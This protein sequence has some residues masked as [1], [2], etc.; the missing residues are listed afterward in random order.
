MAFDTRTWMEQRTPKIEVRKSIDGLTWLVCVD[1]ANRTV[2][3]L[4]QEQAERVAETISYACALTARITVHRI[5][6][7]LFVDGRT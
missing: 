3:K 6:S 4:T 2:E 5:Q 1:G 7:A